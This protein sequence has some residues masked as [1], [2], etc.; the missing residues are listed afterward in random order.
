MRHISRWAPVKTDHSDKTQRGAVSPVR[1]RIGR[2][3]PPDGSAP[4]QFSPYAIDAIWI[5]GRWWL[6]T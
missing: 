4:T 1:A 6:V 2:P 5:L 3:V